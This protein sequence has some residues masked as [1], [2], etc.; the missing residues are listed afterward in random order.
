MFPEKKN[1][2]NGYLGQF[3]NTLITNEAPFFQE[4]DI[5]KR[6][7]ILYNLEYIKEKYPDVVADFVLRLRRF[8][9]DFSKSP[10][11]IPS[12]YTRACSSDLHIRYEAIYHEHEDIPVPD[13][14]PKIPLKKLD[15]DISERVK[16]KVLRSA[17]A[18]VSNLKRKKD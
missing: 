4:F 5:T 7:S 10:F 15:S 17:N 16:E 18:L 11:V 12:D 2:S 1:K 6:I 13:V 14:I 8:I 3:N 9:R